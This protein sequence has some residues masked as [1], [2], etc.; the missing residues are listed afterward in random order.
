M[1]NLPAGLAHALRASRQPYVRVTFTIGAYSTSMCSRPGP[2]SADYP[3]ALIAVRPLSAAIR[4]IQTRE[5]NVGALALTFSREAGVVER[6]ILGHQIKAATVVV[7]L[8]DRSTT[9]TFPV[10]RGYVDEVEE[11]ELSI[12]IKVSDSTVILRDRKF[13]GA[14]RRIHPLESM[15]ELFNACGV[16]PALV[17]AASFDPSLDQHRSHL[18]INLAGRV[19][20]AQASTGTA[21]GSYYAAKEVLKPVDAVPMMSALLAI[22]GGSTIPDELGVFAY[23]D[24]AQDADPVATIPYED[25]EA[26]TPVSKYGHIANR[27]DLSLRHVFT[28]ADDSM[29]LFLENAAKQAEYGRTFETRLETELCNG[30]GFAGAP[31]GSGFINA[32]TAAPFSWDVSGT[33]ANGWSGHR[34]AFDQRVIGGTQAA[35]AEMSADRPLYFAAWGGLRT[36]I[37]I[38][39]A[40]AM[41]FSW[42]VRETDIYG[43]T[44][45]SFSTL[46]V[47]A[48]G[49]FGTTPLTH[50][51]GAV[52]VDVTPF[53]LQLQRE[54]TRCQDGV[55]EVELRLPLWWVGLEVGD[56]VA[57]DGRPYVRTGLVG[58]MVGERW[59]VVSKE[60]RMIGDDIGCGVRLAWKRGSAAPP[61]VTGDLDPD[62]VDIPDAGTEA[63]GTQSLRSRIVAGFGQS[64]AGL[65]ATIDPGRAE[66]RRLHATRDIP[67]DLA[68]TDGRD[69]YLSLDMRT[70][71]VVVRDRATTDPAPTFPP[72]ESALW[73]LR[74]SGGVVTATED[75]RSAV[76]LDGAGLV[77]DSVASSRLALPV[78]RPFTWMETAAAPS[79]V[80]DRAVEYASAGAGATH[81]LDVDLPDDCAAL[82]ECEVSA[83]EDGGG[84][85]RGVWR[86]RARV[87]RTGGAAG[88]VSD[89][90]ATYTSTSDVSWAATIVASASGFALEVDDGGSA[91]RWAL[92]VHYTVADPS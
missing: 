85:D 69:N 70:G 43:D 32:A 20:Q 36:P 3:P 51:T 33:F 56:T 73:R 86:V 42:A 4:D 49:L 48:R 81:A 45:P 92:H 18:L 5:Y 79:R 53:V 31:G 30:V 60:D 24:Y 27:I 23:H 37:E 80:V 88:V 28:N 1:R 29:H 26:M 78:A 87:S 19:S 10:W 57:V 75:L 71:N 63:D 84:A 61:A 38:F 35:W 11:T 46:T 74:T 17:D 50:Q 82:V 77:A 25:I 41:T 15:V 39:R 89:L 72:D 58:G 14:F 6:F 34:L 83:C 21:Q 7:S 54:L 52:L 40:E 66:G 65:V 91:I 59:E 68:L 47:T 16:D 76:V 22:M 2:P 13:A 55:P 12:N 8:C 9:D 67:A 64:N 90:D 62:P 44:W